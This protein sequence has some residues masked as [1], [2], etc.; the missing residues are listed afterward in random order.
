MRRD[1]GNA[2]RMGLFPA[3]LSKGMAASHMDRGAAAQVRQREIHPAV[4]PEGCSQKGKSRLVL[5]YRQELPIA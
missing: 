1:L 4:T 3:S 2:Q 5:V